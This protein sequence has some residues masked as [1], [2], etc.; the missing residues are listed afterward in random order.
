M[1]K[2]SC[3]FFGNFTVFGKIFRSHITFTADHNKHSLLIKRIFIYKFCQKKL[4]I[5]G[6]TKNVYLVRFDVT[7]GLI[8]PGG[9]V[10]KALAIAYIVH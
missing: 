6:S 7:F 3:F 2:G 8:H 1:S 4:N 5:A 9:N 10:S